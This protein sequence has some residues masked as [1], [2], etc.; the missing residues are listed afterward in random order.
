MG[1]GYRVRRALARLSA[2]PPPR[3]RGCGEAGRLHLPLSRL[4]ANQ[5]GTAMR[6]RCRPRRQGWCHGQDVTSLPGERFPMRP[7]SP[8]AVRSAL[9]PRRWS[10]LVWRSV[11]CRWERRM[12][13]W[14]S[15]RPTLKKGRWGPPASPPPP[16]PFMPPSQLTGRHGR[17]TALLDGG[18]DTMA[19]LGGRGCGSRSN[20][21]STARESLTRGHAPFP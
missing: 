2:H 8:A 21:P 18:A 4:R 17:T 16:T 7:L 10:P 1:D 3:F 20:P 9:G 13:S 14:L 15:G 11:A 19:V 5:G 6:E 12:G